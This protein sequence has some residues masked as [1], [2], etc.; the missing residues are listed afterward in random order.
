MWYAAE[1]PYR[2]EEPGLIHEG[3]G[4]QGVVGLHPFLERLQTSLCPVLRIQCGKTADYDTHEFRE[5]KDSYGA[6]DLPFS[7]GCGAE[8]GHGG[9]C[10]LGRDF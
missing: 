4:R 1:V 10:R 2:S 7:A 5:A 3:A 8:L 6:G 9:P